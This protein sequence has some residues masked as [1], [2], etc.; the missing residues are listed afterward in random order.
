MTKP[1]GVI[2]AGGASRRFGSPKAF[3]TFRGLPLYHHVRTAL[4]PYVER[5][6]IISHPDLVERF[7][8]D[9]SILV[10]Q[11]L[12]AYRGKGPLAGIF[13]ALTL[14]EAEDFFV[15]PCDSPLIQSTYI[16]WLLQ[17]AKELPLAKGIVPT[18]QGQ[19][20]PLMGLYRK[21]CLPFLKTLLELNQL[22]VKAL[23][24]TAQI[25]ALEV[26]PNVAGPTFYN[27]NTEQD[28]Q[29]I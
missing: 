2:L 28:L 5:L 18:F 29:G 6:I 9:S 8:K 20:H 17:Q 3:A 21:Q 19:L 22:R 27:V 1:V 4:E 25:P 16:N 23:I 12:P 26:P 14:V 10:L 13:S 11:D 15:V 24:Q 7:S